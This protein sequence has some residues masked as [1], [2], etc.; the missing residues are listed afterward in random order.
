M[1]L[2]K[3]TP[4]VVL[5]SGEIV[6]ANNQTN[7]DLFQTLKG[8][9]NNFGIVT[10]IDLT[11]FPFENLW[12]GVVTYPGTSAPE[13][14]SAFVNFNNKIEDDPYASVIS[15]WQSSASMPEAVVVNAYEYTKPEANPPILGEYL[16]I[17]GNISDSMRI[18]NLQDITDELEQAPGS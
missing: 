15:F 2:T 7:T 3:Y 12:G 6:N 10:K 17:P 13:Q 5:S 9:S 18:T 14:I 16:S 11:A 4:Q 1:Q 8:G